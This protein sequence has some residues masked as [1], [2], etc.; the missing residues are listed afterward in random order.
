MAIISSLPNCTS[1]QPLDDQLTNRIAKFLLGRPGNRATESVA[2]CALASGIGLV[3]DQNQDAALIVKA[4]YGSGPDRDFDL[5][6]VCDGLGGMQHGGEASALGLSVF[7]SRVV[8]FSRFPMD[9][10]LLNGVVEAN[11]RLFGAFRGDGGTTLSA[12]A[13]GRNGLATICHVGDSR[14]Y[15]IGDNSVRQLTHDDTLQA[16]LQKKPDSTN[17]Q[18]DTRLLQFVGMGADLEAQLFKFNPSGVKTYLLTSDGAHDIPLS[19]LQRVVYAA[20]SNSDLAR[21]LV[22]L[23]EILGG[24]DNA[25]AV[26]LPALLPENSER[27]SEGLDLQLISAW[28]QLAIWIPQLADEKRGAP[29]PPGSPAKPPPPPADNPQESPAPASQQMPSQKPKRTKITKKKKRSTSSDE[30]PLVEPLTIHFPP[31][32]ET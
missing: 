12:V 15:A 11:D 4:R 13:V 2:D 16:A 29:P 25:T 3:R 19:F 27:P 18:R 9:N 5:A 21:K 30:L 28:G 1:E 6:V 20:R 8:R 22:Q 14:V 17:V 10:R 32:D 23:S 26:T 31:D 7:V 24:F